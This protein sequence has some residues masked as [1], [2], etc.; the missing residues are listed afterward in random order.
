[1][2]IVFDL[3]TTGLPITPGFMQY[4]PPNETKYYDS[5]RIVQIAY[6]KLDENNQEIYRKNKLVK[7]LDFKITNSTFHGITQ[8]KAMKEGE[9][10]KDI[11]ASLVS[12]LKDCKVLIGH[13]ILFDYNILL[14]ECYRLGLV[15]LIITVTKLN[16]YCTMK[17]GK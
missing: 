12:D 15:D 2:K 10:M 4:Y 13:N 1:M 7:P 11:L 8:E 16:L 17:E 9:E 3:E 5:S 6:I 14:S